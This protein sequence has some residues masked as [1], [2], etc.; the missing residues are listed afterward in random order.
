M[1]LE[2]G[3]GG[4]FGSGLT[5]LISSRPFDDLFCFVRMVVWRMSVG[6]LLGFWDVLLMVGE[7]GKTDGKKGLCKRQT[8]GCGKMRFF[9]LVWE[10]LGGRWD[11]MLELL[12][13]LGVRLKGQL[14]LIF[15]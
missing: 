14:S 7:G 6:Y 12:V 11:L 10:F 3:K 8:V 13:Y 1:V 2:G 4:I 9:V 5:Y 15:S